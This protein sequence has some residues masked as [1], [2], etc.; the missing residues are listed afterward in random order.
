MAEEYV[1]AFEIRILIRDDQTEESIQV[2]EC[3]A[4]LLAGVH[5][6]EDEGVFLKRM[7]TV[8]SRE[9]LYGLDTRQ[10]LVHVHRVQERLVK[11][12][13]VLLRHQEYLVFLS[14]EFL[15]QSLLAYSA[16]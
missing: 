5:E 15:G 14:R 6:V 2:A 8:Q 4:D 11:P 12:G 7:N 1:Q 9:G 13:L 3:L 16:I 10:P